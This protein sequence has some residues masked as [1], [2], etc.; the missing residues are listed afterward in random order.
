MSVRR[1]DDGSIVLEG[2]CPAEDAERLMELLQ[3]APVAS[4]DW[5]PCTRLH[6]AVLQV[7]LAARPVLVGDCGDPWMRQWL[8]SSTPN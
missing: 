7:I 6:T 4:L 2:D 3:T 1:I 5:R 8:P